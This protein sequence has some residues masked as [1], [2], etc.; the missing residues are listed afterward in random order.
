MTTKAIDDR[1][2]TGTSTEKTALESSLGADNAGLEFTITGGATYRWNGSSFNEISTGGAVHVTN[3]MRATA[4]ASGSLGGTSLAVAMAGAPLSCT[5]ILDSSDA[6][7]KIQ[8]SA[9]GG[10]EY[11]DAIYDNTNANELVFFINTPVTH[12]KFTGLSADTYRIG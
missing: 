11:F 9:D 6:T 8:W 3:T 2:L 7:R 12:I 5:V 1:K 4:F 10:T